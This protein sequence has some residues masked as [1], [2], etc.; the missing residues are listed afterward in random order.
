M[1]H[2]G[3]YPAVYKYYNIDGLE[4]EDPKGLLE[5]HPASWAVAL[6]IAVAIP[7]E[8]QNL[9]LPLQHI[10]HGWSLNLELMLNFG[11]IRLHSLL[12]LHSKQLGKLLDSGC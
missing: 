1:T 8:S 5:M 10:L 11:D 2:C 9:G 7:V 4:A 12:D 6:A 3:C